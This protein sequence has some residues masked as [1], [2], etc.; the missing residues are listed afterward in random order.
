M[1][2]LQPSFAHRELTEAQTLADL[3]RAARY[4]DSL[5]V[6]S[7]EGCVWRGYLPAVCEADLRCSH[8]PAPLRHVASLGRHGLRTALQL[9]DRVRPWVHALRR[10]QRPH[11]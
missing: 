1:A 3:R 11:S 9:G 7:L 8:A 6:F 5:Y 10:W 4:T 2:S